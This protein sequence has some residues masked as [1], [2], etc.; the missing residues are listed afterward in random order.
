MRGV[1]EGQGE[2]EYLRSKYSKLPV[3]LKKRAEPLRPGG[4]GLCPNPPG[5]LPYE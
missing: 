4:S 1:A 3:F 2:F 5:H